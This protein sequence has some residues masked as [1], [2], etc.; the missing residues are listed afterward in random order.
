MTTVDPRVTLPSHAAMVARI[1]AVYDGATPEE[2]AAGEAWYPHAGHV[3]ATIAHSTGIDPA[4]VTHALAALSPRNPWRWNVFD[5]YA[6]CFAS[7]EGLPMPS[8][9][10]F[11]RNQQAAWRAL[12]DD[13]QP[14]L[15]A[16]PKVRAFVAAIM[17]DPTA[18]VVDT[19]AYRVAVGRPPLR[20]VRIPEYQPIADAYG[21]AAVARG[22]T[23]AA[24][25][26]VTWIAAQNEG[27]ASRRKGRHDLAFKAGTPEFLK[28]VLS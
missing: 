5:C 18:V 22:V 23:P 17:G 21:I 2:R 1:I 9:T 28:E 3:V 26:A 25:Q 11:R 15:T 27:L 6:Y 10:T 13:G 12:H 19:W 4:R 7:R 14:W 8:A 24:M 20:A 16:A